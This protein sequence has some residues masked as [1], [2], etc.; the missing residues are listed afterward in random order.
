MGRNRI[1]IQFDGFEDMAERL[2]RSAGK[3]EAATEKA[4]IKSQK[5]VADKLKADMDKHRRSGDT[6]KSIIENGEVTWEQGKTKATIRVGFKLSEGGWPSIFLMYG[7]PKM[8]PDKKLYRDVYGAATKR[9]LAAIQQEIF[10]DALRDLE[11]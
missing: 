8:R 6:E 2:S 5:L 11:G 3:L 7:T 1:G 10:K 4:L 9:E